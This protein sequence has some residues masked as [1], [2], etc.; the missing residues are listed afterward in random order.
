MRVSLGWILGLALVSI[1]AG[2]GQAG[3]PTPTERT[4][5]ATV[6]SLPSPTAR[7]TDTATI[8]PTETATPSLQG[9]ELLG[10]SWEG[11]PI[12][13]HRFGT[14]PRKVVLV[15]NIHGGTE[16]NTHQL[17]Q[18]MIAYFQENADEMP[19]EVTLWIIPTA[20]PDGLENDTRCNAH[21]VDL[22]RNADTDSDSCVENDWAQDTYTTETIIEGG[23]GPYPF[24]EVEAQLLRDFAGDAEVAI[25]YHSMAG[26]IFVTSCADHAPSEGLARRLSE[27]TGYP[28][29]EEGWA[30]YPV[31]GAIVDYLAYHGVAAV[32]VE[33]TT[34][35]DTE[36]E[37]NLAGVRAVLQSLDEIASSH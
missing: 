10:K 3:V 36:F 5:G 22:N 18:E 9:S 24:S 35:V 33:L 37:R 25:F 8:A 1:L 20:N 28:F 32:E 27:A 16:V 11:H 6:C 23:G 4:S 29:A 15:G 34:K 19:P 21:M 26:M 13:A 7:V 2:C 30:S 12:V 14:G 17:A 31:T